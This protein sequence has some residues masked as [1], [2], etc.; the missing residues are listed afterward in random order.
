MK[1]DTQEIDEGR[2]YIGFREA[3]EII[4]ANLRPV[5]EEEVSLAECSGRISA[6]DI[7]TQVT[8][9]SENISLKD[10][11]AVKSKNLAGA[12]TVKPVRFK[13]IGSAFAGRKYPG[14]IKNGEAVRICSGARIPEG[15][16]AVVPE[17]FSAEVAPG[18]VDIIADA[19]I[20]RNIMRAGEEVQ[21]GIGLIGRGAKL[22]PGILGLAAAAGISKIKVYRRI[23]VAI[24]GIGD[25]I[26][27][28]GQNLRPGQLYASNLVTMASW[29]SLFNIFH[30]SSV[31]PDDEQAIIDELKKN[32][33]N[34]DAVLTS[35][36]AWDSERD[37]IVRAL[38]KLGWCESFHYVRMGPGKGVAFGLWGNL[39]VFCLPGGPASNQM[40]FLQMALP[41]LLL[42]CGDTKHPLQ[43]VP[44]VLTEDIQG[45]HNNWTEFKDA[46]VTLEENGCYAAALYKNKSRLQSIANAT[47]FIC[48]P[49]GKNRLR[50][51][52]VVPVQLLTPRLDDL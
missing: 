43:T 18:E 23:R 4:G 22:L 29:L 40:A 45:R 44:A 49:E 26:V 36:G 24:I 38:G 41:G 14:R 42:M 31:V 34:V 46:V 7:K 47:G 15:A 27:A 8:Y 1:K 25:E 48:I 5:G 11:Y 35:G 33:H 19:E 51:G 13:V 9:P 21:A 50:K 12:K 28:P 16:D 17:E 6:D 20:G 39:P 30:V 37:L 32:Q 2:D 52:E 10:G 3:L